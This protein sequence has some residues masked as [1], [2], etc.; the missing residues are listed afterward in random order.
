MV[1]SNN[2]INDYKKCRQI[3][4]DLDPHVTGAMAQCI[5]PNRAHPWLHAKPL[6]AAIEKVPT[7]YPPGGSHG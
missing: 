6:D 2:R 5:S 7:P 3:D 1:M 4:N